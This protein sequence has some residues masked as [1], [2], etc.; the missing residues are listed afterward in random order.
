MESCL[1][2]VDIS[3]NYFLSREDKASGL[4]WEVSILNKLSNQK[5]LDSLK[6]LIRF[7]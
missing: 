5:I 4:F 7:I 6:S 3:K 1:Y 2:S